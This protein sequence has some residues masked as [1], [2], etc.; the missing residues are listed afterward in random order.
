[1][2]K[3]TIEITK[4][5]EQL[6]KEFANNHFPGSEANNATGNP[7]FIVQ[8]KVYD[9]IPYN[10]E[11]EFLFEDTPLTFKIDVYGS[12]WIESEVEAVESWFLLI[13]ENSH[14]EIKPYEEMIYNEYANPDDELITVE[15]YNDYFQVF[16]VEM[17]E[18]AWRKESYVDVATFFVRPQ[19]EAYMEYQ[20]HNLNEPRIYTKGPGYANNGDFIPF[21]NLL[22]FI[23][24]ELVKGD[25]ENEGTREIK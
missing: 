2:T 21:R 9:S 5:Q 25:K 15:N 16:G 22:F 4:E 14:I 7:Y 12:Q 23:G 20:S 24:T 18:I 13:G 6:L 10:S 19:A 11:I 3:V 8:S 1:M 17:K